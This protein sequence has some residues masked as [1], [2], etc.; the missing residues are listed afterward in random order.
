MITNRKG[1]GQVPLLSPREYQVLSL[2]KELGPQA[3]GAQIASRLEGNIYTLLHR[4][5]REGWLIDH[6]A[7]HHLDEKGSQSVQ[8]VKKVYKLTKQGKRLHRLWTITCNLWA[9]MQKPTTAKMERPKMAFPIGPQRYYISPQL[10]PE[11][12]ASPRYIGLQQL[13]KENPRG[14]DG[15]TLW[16]VSLDTEEKTEIGY[17]DGKGWEVYK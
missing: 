12:E 4:L 13:K 16:R 15:N 2:V 9:K 11:E 6:V 7:D 10:D 14:K 1:P 3:Y 5:A 17:W 8:R